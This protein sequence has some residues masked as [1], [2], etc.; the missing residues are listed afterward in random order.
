MIQYIQIG[1]TSRDCTANYKI[2]LDKKYTVREFISYV[3]T[4]EEWGDIYIERF[5]STAVT[6]SKN[7]FQA[8]DSIEYKK[9]LVSRDFA[10]EYNDLYIKEVYSFGGWSR[11]DYYLTLEE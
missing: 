9:N 8:E 7:Y 2:K 6:N 5:S 10:E 1:E 11:M 3:L 4:R